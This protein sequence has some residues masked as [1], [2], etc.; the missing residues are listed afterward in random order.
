MRK[1]LIAALVAL[2]ATPALADYRHHRYEQHH[3]YERHHHY[4]NPAPWIAGG[5]ALGV[6]GAYALTPRYAP[7]CWDE[8]IV[9]FAGRQVYNRYGQPLFQRYCE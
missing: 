9:D 7:R 3:R 5:L 8:P 1:L 6:L 4:H 2:S